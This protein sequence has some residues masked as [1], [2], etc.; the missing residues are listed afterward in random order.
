LP[1]NEFGEPI[2]LVFDSPSSQLS[3]LQGRSNRVQ[4]EPAININNSL[5]W[6][7]MPESLAVT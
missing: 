7:T 4:R 5:V 6:V 2:L 1:K 3:G